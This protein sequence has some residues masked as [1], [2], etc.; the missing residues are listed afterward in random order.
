MEISQKVIQSSSIV[1]G[2]FWGKFLDNTDMLVV[3]KARLVEVFEVNEQDNSVYCILEQNLGFEVRLTAKLVWSPTDV[4]VCSSGNML[5][6]LSFEKDYFQTSFSISLNTTKIHKIE[7]YSDYIIISINYWHLHIY[8]FKSRQLLH[9]ITIFSSIIDWHLIDSKIQVLEYNKETSFYSWHIINTNNW[10]I[11]NLKPLDV[12]LIPIKFI[13]FDDNLLVF[14]SDSSVFISPLKDLQTGLHF[15]LN[16][17]YTDSTIVNNILYIVT[18]NGTFYSF[19]KNLSIEAPGFLGK[20]KDYFIV[21]E[22]ANLEPDSKI[23]GLGCG[24]FI[25]N[26]YGNQQIFIPSGDLVYV[27]NRNGVLV[28]GFLED[29]K[30]SYNYKTIKVASSGYE[31]SKIYEMYRSLNVCTIAK[32]QNISKYSTGGCSVD[33]YLFVLPDIKAV[34]SESYKVVELDTIGLIEKA[35]LLVL[36]D[37]KC[38][39]CGRILEYDKQ[40][41]KPDEK[42]V[43]CSEDSESFCKRNTW[44]DGK[45]QGFIQVTDQNILKNSIPIFLFPDKALQAVSKSPYLCVGLISQT[46]LIFNNFHQQASIT[47]VDFSSLFIDN[48]IYIGLHS[49]SIKKYSLNGQELNTIETLAIPHTFLFYYNHLFIGHRDGS[50]QIFSSESSIVHKKLGEKPLELCVYKDKIIVTTDKVYCIHNKHWDYSLV[51]IQGMKKII[52]SSI[53]IGISHDVVF[54][55]LEEELSCSLKQ[56]L[57]K[58]LKG[59]IRRM[60]KVKKNLICCSVVIKEKHVVIMYDYENNNELSVEIE[61]CVNH[62]RY[63]S[64]YD[65]LIIGVGIKE[66]DTDSLAEGQ[67]IKDAGLVYFYSLDLKKLNNYKFSYPVSA[68]YTE[69]H[70]LY[71]AAT[72]ILYAIN[73]TNINT[74]EK[75]GSFK[76]RSYINSIE[77]QNEHIFI[78]T[79]HDGILGLILQQNTFKIVFYSKSRFSTDVI[80][81]YK[82]K[83]ISIGLQ[84]FISILDLES[85]T[86][87]KVNIHGGSRCMFSGKIS[88]H[89]LKE[90]D[91]KVLTVCC[92]NGE[93]IEVAKDIDEN[94]VKITKEVYE[95]FIMEG[96]IDIQF[97]LEI[98]ANLLKYFPKLS[99]ESKKSLKLEFPDIEEKL[100][101]L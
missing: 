84:G 20:Y 38:R 78:A 60:I 55:D 36:L 11:K 52:N 65:C 54:F 16:G 31:N 42:I 75:I 70:T 92:L 47:Q 93:I 82:T 57:V 5:K 56:C 14:G 100:R 53:L 27:N 10:E 63:W 13:N 83:V 28:D 41:N 35:T 2:L 34:D 96:I 21:K 73:V 99:E 45:T 86:S 23:I 46:V 62:I 32:I 88:S 61:G 15:M 101:L 66:I 89:N 7:T 37:D 49:C 76:T 80:C 40:T 85:N 30:G 98:N 97:P 81:L 69:N 51:D 59:R 1:H 25:S 19:N 39:C 58:E 95:A 94:V 3:I 6:F 68:L 87:S 12:K 26:I 9:E 74:A 29:L 77:K 67:E 91:D 50:L 90:E 64:E 22:N 43:L 72:Y 33:K 4:I 17:V 71:I 44:S 79:S 18:D 48:F 8:S 24:I